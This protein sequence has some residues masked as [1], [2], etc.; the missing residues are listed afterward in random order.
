MKKLFTVNLDIEQNPSNT[1]FNVSTLDSASV[2]IT[3]NVLESA[4]A[5]NITGVTPVLDIM[6]PDGTTV[7]QAGTITNATGGVL[8]VVLPALAT[9]LVGL[10]SALLKITDVDS[11]VVITNSFQY[12]VNKGY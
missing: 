4:I 1:V 3:I 5:K 2:Q 7:T 11:S 6:K 9:A 10:H 8:T 12:I